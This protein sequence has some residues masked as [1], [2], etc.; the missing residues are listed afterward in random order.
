[1]S[2]ELLL[3]QLQPLPARHQIKVRLRTSFVIFYFSL[4]TFP[5]YVESEYRYFQKL[6]GSI[7]VSST[8]SSTTDSTYT[9]EPFPTLP[10]LESPNSTETTKPSSIPTISDLTTVSPK[11]FRFVTEA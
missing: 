4:R 3:L 2:S 1:M 7:V 10:P 5:K 8:S 11:I 6:S 9:L